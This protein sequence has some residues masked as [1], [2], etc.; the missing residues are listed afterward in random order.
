LLT[1]FSTDT[2]IAGNGDKFQFFKTPD[3]PKQGIRVK[4]KPSGGAK[5]FGSSFFYMILPNSRALAIARRKPNGQTGPKGGRYDILYGPSLSQV[6]NTV[7]DDVLP[8]ASNEFQAQLLDAM[9]FVLVKQF[10]KE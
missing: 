8:E 4:V 7:R 1:R 9:R 3:I 6:F 5:G 10:P 2:R